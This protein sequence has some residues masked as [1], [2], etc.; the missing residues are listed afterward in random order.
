[1]SHRPKDTER[2]QHD[3]GLLID[4]VDFIGDGPDR[5]A[6]AGGK[7]G[8]FG[9][10]RAP[11]EGIDDGLGFFAGLFGGEVGCVARWVEVE[12]D[13]GGGKGSDGEG[14]E[15]GGAWVSELGF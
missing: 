14:P 2:R 8:G 15:S 4:N 7:D 9:D 3:N 10:E 11:R 12:T 13:R 5:D 6:G 1:M